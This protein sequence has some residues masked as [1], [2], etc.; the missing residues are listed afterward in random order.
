M[1]SL[2]TL[3][4]NK[5]YELVV[6][7]TDNTEDYLS[8]FY[9]MSALL[10]L[11]RIEE[12]L[13]V[14]DK[15][16]NVLLY[17]PSLLIK[18]HIEILCLLGRFDDAFNALTDYKELPY[19]SQETEE[20]LSSMTDYIRQEEKKSYQT[21]HIDEDDVRKSLFSDNDDEVIFALNAVRKMSLE[22]FLLPILKILRSHKSQFVRSF[23]LLLLVD[24]K[25]DKEV[26]YLHIDKLIKVVPAKLDK[27]FVV[28]G[29][30][31]KELSFAFQSAFHDPSLEETAMHILSSY[32]IYIYP[33]TIDLNKEEVVVLFAYLGYKMLHNDSFD[34]EK[35]CQTRKLDYQKLTLI[36]EKIESVIQS[37]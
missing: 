14:I 29:Y 11:G 6:K 24:F 15:H 1:D 26:D 33:E 16:K 13:G 3:M 20:L 30:D 19:E 7:L 27:P 37:F 9:R 12:A 34:F 18:F 10:A 21:Q 2:K 23:A 4:D 8:L 31:V 35:E 22:T 32:L 17:K 5:N 28:A 36:A 25:Y